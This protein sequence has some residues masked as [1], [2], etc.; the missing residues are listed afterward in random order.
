M[1]RRRRV[2]SVI[3]C[4]IR[5]LGF[6]KA[7]FFHRGDVGVADTAPVPGDLDREADRGAGFRVGG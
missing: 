1:G 5:H 3:N 6:A 7:G 4:L 2:R